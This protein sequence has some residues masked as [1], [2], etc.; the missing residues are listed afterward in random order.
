V[1]EVLNE[2]DA[3]QVPELIVINKADVADPHTLAELTRHHPGA[4]VVSART[5]LG[6]EELLTAIEKRLPSLLE[7]VDVLVPYDRGDLVSRA[8]R[9]GEVVSVEHG[10]T[11]TRLVAKVP[12]ALAG[13]LQAA[14]RG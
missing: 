10:E 7:D 3:G 13:E 9:Q 2:I 6:I 12:R 4:V 8:H 5:G 14:V 11:G 1:R